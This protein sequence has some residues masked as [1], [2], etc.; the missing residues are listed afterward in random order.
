MYIHDIILVESN[1]NMLFNIYKFTIII[2]FVT[3]PNYIYIYI[4]Y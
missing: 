1:T 3:F 2:I 4:F